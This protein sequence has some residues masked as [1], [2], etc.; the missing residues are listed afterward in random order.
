M[1]ILRLLSALAVAVASPAWPQ[2]AITSLAEGETPLQES[3]DLR[4][5][6][7]ADFTEITR[8]TLGEDLDIGDLLKSVSG[9]TDVE[10]TCGESSLL[11]FS[12]GFRVVINPPGETDCAVNLLSGQLDVLTDAPTE[13]RAGGLVLG[14]E[15]TQYAITLERD[16]N[17][18]RESVV[19][20]DGKLSLAGR[21]RDNRQIDGES[22]QVETGQ[23]WNW[24]GRQANWGQ[25]KASDLARAA[26]VYARFDLAKSKSIRGTSPSIDPAVSRSQLE[27]L[28]TKVL[29]QPADEGSRAALAKAQLELEID[30]AAV[31]NLKRVQ[32]DDDTKLR[33]HQIDPAFI[34]QTQRE[35]L[36]SP[37]PSTSS[38][39]VLQP[40]P[41]RLHHLVAVPAPTAWQLLDRQ[42][43]AK[44]LPALQQLSRETPSARV[45][46]GLAQAHGG[47][48][49]WTS[50]TAGA[51]AKRALRLVASGQEVPAAELRICQILNDLQN[52]S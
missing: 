25:V 31:Y 13:V 10:L 46:C 1:R 14:S 41:P 33:A 28:H 6:R 38:L 16:A 35:K 5:E 48:E 17:G 22:W 32:L 29:S 21:T 20:F 50:H 12:G 23:T 42:E 9:A 45:Y 15:G 7:F 8:L 47:I 51:Y 4:L 43:Y 24:D 11:R 39:Q 49:G 26:Q 36:Y 19:V 27:A 2:A 44:A 52:P 3:T 40:P 18:P 34:S 37:R 30:Q